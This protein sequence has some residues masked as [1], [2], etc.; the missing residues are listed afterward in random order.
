MDRKTCDKS[1]TILPNVCRQKTM[2]T[3]TVCRSGDCSGV[4]GLFCGPC[5]KNR[6]GE[7]VKEAL[8]DPVSI[9]L[10]VFYRIEA[11]LIVT[12]LHI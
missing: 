6:Y 2:D 7:E 3:K 1:K 10:V 11:E 9:Y 5:L 4:R 8:L 12:Q